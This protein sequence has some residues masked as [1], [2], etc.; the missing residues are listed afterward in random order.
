MSSDVPGPSPFLLLLGRTELRAALSSDPGST[1]VLS[2]G[3]L[4]HAWAP[5]LT[6]GVPCFF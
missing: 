5:Q 6:R 2:R 1:F 3:V 4:E